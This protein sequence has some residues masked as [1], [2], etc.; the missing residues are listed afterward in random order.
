DGFMPYLMDSAE[1]RQSLAYVSVVG[2][3]P[4]L[5]LDLGQPYALSRIHLHAVDQSDTVP[6][7]YAGDLGI[8]H[9]L[10]IEGAIH[11]DFSDA[12]TLLDFLREDIYDTGPIM[13]WRIPR[14]NCRFIR[15]LAVDSGNIPEANPSRFRFGFAEIELFSKGTN[16]AL[17]K[18]AQANSATRNPVRSSSALTDGNNLYGQILP[19]REWLEQLARRHDLEA[20]RPILT[21][22]LSHRYARQKIYLRSLGWLVALLAVGTVII[23]LVDRII[24]QHAIYRT[25]QRIAADLH[26]ELGANLH[27]IGLLSDLTQNAQESPEKLG[28]L[29][30]RL[31]ALTE[32]TGAAARH[33]TNMLEA[34]GLYENLVEDMRR[35]SARLMA[36]LEHSI[37]IEGEERVQHIKPR[38]R[39]D[40]FLFYKECLTNVL[41]HSNATQVT[42]KLVAQQGLIT[43]TITDNGQGLGQTN[44]NGVPR[45][46]KRR[47]RFLGAQVTTGPSTEGGACITLKL[48]L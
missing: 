28:K 18:S 11:P 2:E 26:D 38:R 14:R 47:A 24:K 45:S 41:R 16:V 10:R 17:N 36:D 20:E 48:R 3:K 7:A 35:T 13:M 43:L 19:I 44:G 12:A 6:Q 22:E 1:G 8:P 23:M 34:E 25:R 40:L 27:A 5:T 46:L 39:V 33:C 4:I 37:T 30:Q 15:F 32:R 21:A 29:L 9:H 42:T 31:R